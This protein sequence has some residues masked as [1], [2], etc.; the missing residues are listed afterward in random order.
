MMFA[1][2]VVC[3][4]APPPDLVP[5]VVTEQSAFVVQNN[6]DA[7][8]Y[9]FDVQEVAF[10]DIGNFELRPCQAY[11]IEPVDKVVLPQAKITDVNYFRLNELNKPPAVTRNQQVFNFNP[12]K[13]NSNYGYP[14]T[15]DN[16]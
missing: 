2:A 5:D 12:D 13:Q 8:V 16:C 14:L 1:F 9:M 15:G 4:A 3:F 7:P 10:V 11:I 6:V